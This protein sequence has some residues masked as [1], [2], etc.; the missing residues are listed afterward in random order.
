MLLLAQAISGLDPNK[1]MNQGL[2]PDENFSDCHN[3][4]YDIWWLSCSGERR[5]YLWGKARM[6][7]QAALR[8]TGAFL[9]MH[10]Y[11]S[12][13]PGISGVTPSL[14]YTWRNPTDAYVYVTK[15]HLTSVSGF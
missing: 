10:K 2:T 7:L 4:C 5:K 8:V 3:S 9:T 12:R 13:D 15:C 14:D 1:E 11:Y 6:R